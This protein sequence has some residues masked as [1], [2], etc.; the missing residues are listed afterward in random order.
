M[1]TLDLL[2]WVGG[3]LGAA[4]YVLV[5]TGRMA[6]TASAFQVLNIIGAVLL[7]LAAF[8]HGAVPSAVMNLAW[9]GFGVQALVAGRVR[10]RRSHGAV[11]ARITSRPGTT[12][13][14]CARA[15]TPR[16]RPAHC[17][18]Q[19]ARIGLRRAPVRSRVATRRRSTVRTA[20]GGG[21][22]APP[23]PPLPA[24]LPTD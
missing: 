17:L 19:G 14:G 16:H 5:S 1:S 6:P 10:R 18:G 21:R 13:A 23:S 15:R 8:H 11:P 12:A 20:P 4:A 2:G 7:G 9:I 3:G 22:I 24:G